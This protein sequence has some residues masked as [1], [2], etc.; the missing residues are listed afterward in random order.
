MPT[1]HAGRSGRRLRNGG[2]A[3][4]LALSSFT[5]GYVGATLPS[6]DCECAARHGPGARAWGW[7][8]TRPS[9]SA[10][11]RAPGQPLALLLPACHRWTSR[12]RGALRPPAPGRVVPPSALR[13]QKRR[14]RPAS[15]VGPHRL[16]KILEHAPPPLAAGGD[17]RPDPLAKA[18]PRLTARPLR[19]QPVD[20]HEA[21]RPLGRVVG[22]L[23]ARRGDEREV[24][25]PVLLEPLGQAPAVLGPCVLKPRPQ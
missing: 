18:L 4:I 12:P 5:E 17:H 9:S 22:R 2:T 11:R 10:P 6:R 23:E 13:T 15:E 19:H 3:G 21:D 1:A 20:H 24:I 8:A 7:P 14:R 25:L 16:L